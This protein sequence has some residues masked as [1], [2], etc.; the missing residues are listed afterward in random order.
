MRTRKNAFGLVSWLAGCGVALLAV[1][2]GGPANA[3][4]PANTDEVREDWELVIRETDFDQT[5]PQ[6]VTVISPIETIESDYGVLE[7]NH[8]TQPNYV[9]GGI[10]LQRWNGDFMRNYRP[11]TAHDRL[12][13]AGERITYTMTMKVSG[14][15][16]EFGVTNGKS[17]TWGDFG[18]TSDQWRSATASNYTDLSRYDRNVSVTKS[19]IGFAA[20]L[21][22][23][24]KQ[25]QVRYYK[26]GQLVKTDNTNLSVYDAGNGVAGGN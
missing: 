18:G 23:S 21:V 26:N 1:L 9:D 20:N 19:R 15:N 2:A 14:G 3:Q 22:Q 5:A 6:I 12:T 16:L 4:T 24:F 13:I 7:L 25:K 8:T 11:P 17:Q 10:Q